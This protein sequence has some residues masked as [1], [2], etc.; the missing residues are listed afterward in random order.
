MVAR[1]EQRATSSEMRAASGS[2]RIAMAN[3]RRKYHEAIDP[4]RGLR[5][6]RPRWGGSRRG[7]CA[8]ANLRREP[9]S[10]DLIGRYP[11]TA[12][13]VTLV[14]TAPVANQGVGGTEGDIPRR[15]VIA[16]FVGL[17]KDP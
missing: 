11:S 15:V 10:A 5:L 16:V 14:T 2:G 3:K 17:T 12:P 13:L 1:S 7:Q 4:E 8:Q 6:C 9:G